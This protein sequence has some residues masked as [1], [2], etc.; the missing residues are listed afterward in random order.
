MPSTGAETSL[1]LK[2]GGLIKVIVF[3]LFSLGLRLRVRKGISFQNLGSLRVGTHL[4]SI[5]LLSFLG[6]ELTGW[7]LKIAAIFLKVPSSLRTH[8]SFLSIVPEGTTAT[9]W[10]Q[11]QPECGQTYICP[12]KIQSNT[13]WGSIGRFLG[14]TVRLPSCW[15]D[16]HFLDPTHHIRIGFKFAFIVSFSPAYLLQSSNPTVKR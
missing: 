3:R 13:L 11:P 15:G 6:N 8:R 16:W 12:G 2:V 9:K 10:Q 7:F 4:L 1:I 5:L 14:L